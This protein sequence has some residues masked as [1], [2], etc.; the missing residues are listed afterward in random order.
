MSYLSK[1]KDAKK[2]TALGKGIELNGFN[3][4]VL[5][6][7]ALCVYCEGLRTRSLGI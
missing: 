3:P 4:W 5:K 1:V 2:V 6:G 7:T